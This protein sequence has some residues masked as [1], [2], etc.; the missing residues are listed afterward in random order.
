MRVA[1]LA[2]LLISLV[3]TGFASGATNPPRLSPSETTC[4]RKALGAEALARLVK[5]KKPWPKKTL[6]K[7]GH[8][9]SDGG[10]SGSGNTACPKSLSA[11]FARPPIDTRLLLTI[12]LPGQVRGSDYKGHGYFRLSRNDASVVLPIAATL[13]EGSRYIEAGEVQYLLYFRTKCG[14]VLVFD[15]IQTPSP[16]VLYAFEGKPKAKPDDSRTYSLPSVPLDAGAP[17]ASV[18]GFPQ[19]SNA[20]VDFGVYD[21]SKPNSASKRP[22]FPGDKGTWRDANAL[23]W[24]DMF[25]ASTNELFRSLAG[26]S[27]EGTS[28]DV[29]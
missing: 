15:H 25:S 4:V 8:C 26:E 13:Y 2:G 21:R 28:S 17:I 10:G 6:Q 14:L 23:C 20:A 1:A 11:Y 5:S 12:G 29:C 27:V 18:V 24:L 16:A 7:A 22:G 9:L 3:L 19:S